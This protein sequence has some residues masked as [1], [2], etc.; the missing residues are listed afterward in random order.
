[1]LE[2]ILLRM[3]IINAERRALIVLPSARRATNQPHVKKRKVVFVDIY[4]W[5]L[6]QYISRFVSSGIVSKSADQYVYFFAG[7]LHREEEIPPILPR[8]LAL[9]L[10]IPA[11][12]C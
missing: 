3:R 2:N 4:C 6:V 12:P 11:P 1:M 7:L 9:H 5:K 8:R 10:L